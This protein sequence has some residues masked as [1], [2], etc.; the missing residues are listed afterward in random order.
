M[1]NLMPENGKT[2]ENLKNYCCE[3]CKTVGKTVVLAQTDGRRLYF[4]IG[5]V[6]TVLELKPPIRFFE[7]R[8]GK[9]G[10]LTKWRGKE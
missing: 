9:C 1:F 7:L 6:A 4:P 2:P 8:C 3:F 10:E 5:D